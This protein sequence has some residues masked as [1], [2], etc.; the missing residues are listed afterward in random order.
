[1]D[2]LGADLGAVSFSTGFASAE[3]FAGELF[4]G[5]A[6]SAAA[7]ASEALFTFSIVFFFDAAV[8]AV[9]AVPGEVFFFL[10]LGSI[11]SGLGNCCSKN[12]AVILS[13][14]QEAA[15]AA[16]MPSSLA[17]SK[18]TLLGRP[19]FLAISYIR[20]GIYFNFAWLC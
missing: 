18:T 8:A 9:A 15:R 20:T 6:L 10:G 16:V 3:G 12:S 7:A 19:N 4:A 14:E 5:D 1:M 13:K 11:S 2:D 17:F